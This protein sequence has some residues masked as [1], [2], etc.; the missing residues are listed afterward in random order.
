[1]KDKITNQVISV[2]FNNQVIKV[3]LKENV[4]NLENQPSQ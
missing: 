3:G 4:T 1:L 2:G